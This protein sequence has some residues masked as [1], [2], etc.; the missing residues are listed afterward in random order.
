MTRASAL[1]RKAADPS[2]SNEARSSA[3][4]GCSIRNCRA[5]RRGGRMVHDSTGASAATIDET[6][7]AFP[8]RSSAGCPTSGRPSGGRAARQ[9]E[10]IKYRMPT[11]VLHGNLVH[12]RCVRTPYRA[13]SHAI[14][15]GTIREGALGLQGRQGV[16]QFPTTGASAGAQ[17]AGS[18]SR[19]GRSRPGRSGR[20]GRPH[21]DGGRSDRE[22][23][24]SSRS[25]ISPPPG[26]L[27]RALRKA[28]YGV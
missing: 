2:V 23:L 8:R 15:A 6:S 18:S 7:L 10:A 19:C 16:V 26:L 12:F 24:P 25:R 14:R 17:S 3:D 21:G 1:T 5:R 4:T 9:E 11:F 22:A 27:A 20:S 13:L 28:Q